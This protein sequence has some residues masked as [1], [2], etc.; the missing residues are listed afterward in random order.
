MIVLSGCLS[1]CNWQG[2]C[3]EEAEGRTGAMGSGNGSVRAVVPG[4][5][6]GDVDGN[7]TWPRCW[8]N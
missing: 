1:P 3:G 6:P 2:P 7:S 4:F 8:E 5:P